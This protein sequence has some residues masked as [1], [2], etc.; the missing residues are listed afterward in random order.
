MEERL[1]TAG[2][3]LEKLALEVVMLDPNDVQGCGV[4]LNRLDALI[5]VFTDTGKASFA[6]LGRAIKSIAEKLVLDEMPAPDEGIKLIEDGVSL[7]QE[8]LRDGETEEAASEKIAKFLNDCGLPPTVH[9]KGEPAR[10]KNDDVEKGD[11]ASTDI[12]QDKE[13]VESFILEA[14][15]HLGT[16]EVNVLKL[17]QKPDNLE[18][19]DAIFRPFHTI[20]GVSG[21]LD[22]TDIN[23]LAHEVE[24]ILD[25]A[26]N[27]KLEVDETVTDLVLDAVDLM[28]G[29]MHHLRAQL[30]TGVVEPADFGL[31]TFL[32]RLTKVQIEDIEGEDE[33]EA[34]GAPAIDGADIGSILVEKG[35]VDEPDVDEA[36]EKQSWSDKKLGEILIE[37]KRV[38]AR[39]V[40]GALREQK[41]LR[42]SLQAGQKSAA[43]ASFLK[44]NTQKLDNMVDM[45]GELVITQAMLGQDISGLVALDK[46]LYGNLAQL[47]RIT[48]EIQ[49]ISTSLRMIPIKQTFQKMIRL[50]RDLS[51]KSGKLV[52]LKMVGEETEIDRN[53]VDELYDPL[54]HMV[55]NSVDHS[56]EEPQVRKAS[57]KSETGTVTLK[58]YHKGGN[59]VIEVSDDGRG[60]DRSKIIQ[61]ALERNLI[62]SGQNL[63]DQEVYSLIFQPGFSTSDGVTEVSGRG[64]GMDVVKRTVDKLRG[65]LEIDSVPGQ[66]T[67][68]LMKVPLTLA[69]IDGIIVLGGGRN[70]I[71]PTASVIESFRPDKEACSSVANRGEMIKIRN[72]LQPLIRLHELFGFAPAHSNPWEAIVVVVESDGRRKCILVDGLIGKQEI[73]IKGLGEQ[74]KE[75]KGMAGGA[76][77]ADGRV[78]LILDV[79]GLF[80][81]SERRSESSHS[82]LG[83]LS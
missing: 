22:L 43:R 17:E 64:V 24:T 61:R 48:S 68:I 72:T 21:F 57:G 55:R 58:A 27:Q 70:F 13:L 9:T 5:Q 4:V 74:L 82:S 56:I 18:V 38:T 73:V 53:M 41:R 79:A 2:G 75:V 31:E 44:V 59:I 47:R 29:M 63:S 52:T 12:S 46:K 42:D 78:G 80:E 49:R 83:S 71:I 32:D 30:D 35:I 51:K 54:V 3:V 23:R 19:I 14:L 25:H 26:R 8:I 16:V 33:T 37:D 65:K 1:S 81:I 60:L 67:R 10:S 15:E 66:G 34:R 69:I 20:K 50:V 62:S 45:V 36:L 28:K 77:L 6:E 7:F 11:R 40:A 76:I 39:D